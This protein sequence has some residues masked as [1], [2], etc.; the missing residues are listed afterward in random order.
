MCADD[1][2]LYDC[3]N[4]EMDRVKFQNELNMFYNWCIQDLCIIWRLFI[5]LQQCKLKHFNYNNP[6]Y[7]YSLVL[8]C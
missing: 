8:K 4:N 7:Q 1:F 6:K 2:T 3:I 5:N